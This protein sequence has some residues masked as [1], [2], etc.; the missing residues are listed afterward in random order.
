MPFWLLIS[1]PAGLS[2][3][4]LNLIRDD[5]L[6]GDCVDS[7]MIYC[8]NLSLSPLSISEPGSHGTMAGGSTCQE[9]RLCWTSGTRSPTPPTYWSH[10]A[11]HWVRETLH[12]WDTITRY[13]RTH[14]TYTRTFTH[15]HVRTLSALIDCQI[16]NTF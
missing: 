8:I 2:P 14:V 3:P 6:M 11:P 1:P 16:S 10:T 12:L 15:A 9:V 13:H 7:D 4:G 5:D